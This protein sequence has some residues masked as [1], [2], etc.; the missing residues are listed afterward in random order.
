[1]QY[2]PAEPSRSDSLTTPPSRTPNAVEN[3]IGHRGLLT[4]KLREL[5]GSVEVELLEAHP[6]RRTLLHAGA[7][8]RV[9]AEAQIP[10]AVV[11]AHRWLCDLGNQP[12]GATLATHGVDVDRSPY[13]TRL[14][15]PGDALFERAAEASGRLDAQA[16]PIRQFALRVAAGPIEI[17]EVFLT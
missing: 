6:R 3:L 11:S 5:Y 1:M 13:A 8:P 10:A 4:D 2:D 9:Y 16:F 17:T 12:L 7:A 15:A 14:V